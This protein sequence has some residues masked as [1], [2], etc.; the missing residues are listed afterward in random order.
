MHVHV[1]AEELTDRVD[2]IEKSGFFGV[3]FHL[4]LPVTVDGKQVRGPFIHR[5]GDDDSA[6]VIFWSKSKD[7]L[8]SL[9]R[10]AIAEI[11]KSQT[12]EKSSN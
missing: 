8:R 1:Y 3:S 4:E 9:M 7:E 6:A 2:I 11:D 10:N 12:A 5:P